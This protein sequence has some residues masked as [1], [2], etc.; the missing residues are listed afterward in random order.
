MQKD[1]SD[2]R[3]YTLLSGWAS[4]VPGVRTTMMKLG[5]TY[6]AG[7]VSAPIFG[8]D[9]LPNP[10][11]NPIL[12]RIQRAMSPVAVADVVYWNANRMSNANGGWPAAVE[13]VSRGV[14]LSR[15][16]VVFNDTFAGTAVDVSWEMHQGAADGAIADQGSMRLAIPLGQRQTITIGVTTPAA[17]TTAVLVLQ[18]SKDGRVI[19]RDDGQQLR[20][21]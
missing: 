5:P 16:L 4:I 15:Q 13:S 6:P 12:L 8:E 2:L 14:R 18:S 11:S 20:L 19:F 21:Q 1:A 10:W 3:P 9:N 17:G 7:V